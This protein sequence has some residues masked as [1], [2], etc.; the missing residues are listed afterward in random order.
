MTFQ[1]YCNPHY[2]CS[3][4]CSLSSFYLS[5]K[6]CS[7]EV[8]GRYL[9][10]VFS[11]CLFPTEVRKNWKKKQS[12]VVIIPKTFGKF[13]ETHM[14]IF[15]S[16]RV[17][18]FCL[19]FAIWNFSKLLLHGTQPACAYSTHFFLRILAVLVTEKCSRRE[20][21][22]MKS[23]TMTWNMRNNVICH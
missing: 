17:E 22:I 6:N 8:E 16:N 5:P 14:E 23:T 21:S 11:K 12:V 13:A 4:G 9:W 10:I 15:L 1:C 2:A 19:I 18:C 20:F 3:L 7:E